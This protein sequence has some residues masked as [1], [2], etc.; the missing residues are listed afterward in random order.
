[1]IPTKSRRATTWLAMLIF[2]ALWVLLVKHLA[3]HWSVNPQ[4]SFGWLVPVL[5]AFMLYRRWAT[6]PSVEPAS[7][8][9]GIGETPISRCRASPAAWIAV[10]VALTFFPTWLV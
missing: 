8:R 10:A 5:C 1:M 4:Y 9:L 2:G 6:R 3:V 7:R